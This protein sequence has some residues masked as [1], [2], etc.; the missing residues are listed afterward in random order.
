MPTK[1]LQ[2]EPNDSKKDPGRTPEQAFLEDQRALLTKTK[3]ES[4]KSQSGT[5]V[6]L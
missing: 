4:G 2:E 3:V 5:S 1:W 6:N